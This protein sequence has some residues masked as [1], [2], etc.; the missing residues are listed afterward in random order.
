MNVVTTGG[1]TH[2]FPLP[3]RRV[4]RFWQRAAFIVIG[5]TGTGKSSIVEESLLEPRK[6]FKFDDRDEDNPH[7]KH[8]PENL[9]PPVVETV[10]FFFCGA[11]IETR[12]RLENNLDPDVFDKVHWLDNDDWS[13]L[14]KS[15]EESRRWEL[16]KSRPR[17]RRH[18]IVFDD[19]V[20]ENEPERKR[21]LALLTKNKRHQCCCIVLL[22][23]QFVGN[24]AAHSI[25]DNCERVYFTRSEQNFTNLLAFTQR[26]RVPLEAIKEAAE[27][28]A[29]APEEQARVARDRV[30]KR[31]DFVA[32]DIQNSCFIGS[33]R[34]FESGRPT[35]AIGTFRLV[36]KS[37]TPPKTASFHCRVQVVGAE[38][39][40]VLL[41][42]GEEA[43][44]RRRKLEARR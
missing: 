20:V 32:Y 26:K 15:F 41:R 24:K 25:A 27:C 9:G 31:F 6:F 36:S 11:S 14:H 2:P 4:F 35:R 33:Y 7:S 10:L 21:V 40:Q 3:T 22:T 17:Q 28:L 12:R 44:A 43:Q 18:V 37:V 34:S 38:H 5:G 23:H 13:V 42:S 39:G 30:K 19:F 8:W 16:S 1:D 29:I